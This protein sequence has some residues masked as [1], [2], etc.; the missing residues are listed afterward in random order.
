MLSPARSLQSSSIKSSRLPIITATFLVAVLALAC[1]PPAA[2]GDDIEVWFEE[3]DH[4]LLDTNDDREQDTISFSYDVDTDARQGTEVHVKLLVKNGH[5][6]AIDDPVKEHEVANDTVEYWYMNWTA[7][8]NDTYTF[9]LRLYHGQHYKEDQT[10]T[11]TVDLTGTEQTGRLEVYSI[12]E[13][14]GQVGDLY[15]DDEFYDD[16]EV[17]HGERLLD[18]LE[19]EP[20]EYQVKLILAND[21]SVTRE[22]EVETGKTGEVELLLEDDEQKTAVHI[23]VHNRF[24]GQMSDLYIDSQLV[25]R[26]QLSKGNNDLGEFE[27]DPG[28]H[29]AYIELDNEAE[30]LVEFTL[31]S[32][33]TEN[34]TLNPEKEEDRGLLELWVNNEFDKQWGHLYIDHELIDEFEVEN[35]QKHL[36]DLHLEPGEH[37]VY[38]VLDNEAD[39]GK[40]FTIQKDKRTERVL[41]PTIKDR[42]INIAGSVIS[43]QNCTGPYDD[44]Y[45]LA[46]I[47]DEPIQGV[48]I[49]VYADDGRG[50]QPLRSGTTN[51]HGWWKT[52]ELEPGRYEWEAELRDVILEEG[53]L[54]VY[55]DLNK[56][57]QGDIYGVGEGENRHWDLFKV[58]ADGEGELNRAK[59]RLTQEGEP[60]AQGYTDREGVFMKDDLPRGWYDYEIEWLTDR[61]ETLALSA[62]QIYSYGAGDEPEEPRLYEPDL[63]PKHGD[64][65]TIFTVRVHYQ[66][67]E[68][69]APL[70]VKF[71]YTDDDY[72]QLQATGS[73]WT[74]GVEFILNFSG[75]RLGAGEY[76]HRFIAKVGDLILK[77][78]EKPGPFIN[79]LHPTI[80]IRAPEDG[81][82][83]IGEETAVLMRSD[84]RGDGPFEIRL[85][86]YPKDDGRGGDGVTIF[87]RTQQEPGEK[88][89]T[90]T[91]NTSKLEPGA[92]KLKATIKGE[93]GHMGE[94]AIGVTKPETTD[95]KRDMALAIEPMV[96]KVKAGREAMFTITV[97]NTGNVADS[98]RLTALVLYVNSSVE[99][100]EFTWKDTALD[101]EAGAYG[102]SRLIVHVPGNAST[103]DV[104]ALSVTVVSVK[105]PGVSTIGYASVLVISDESGGV[106]PNLSTPTAIAALTTGVVVASFRRR[107]SE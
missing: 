97:T 31:E 83:L 44:L 86:Y 19:L 81:D 96:R 33:E 57:A 77:T 20:G 6:Q 84:A 55:E 99:G 107:L 40:P 48:E 25:D 94:D 15:L 37:V 70:W 61:N 106:M 2:G 3:V 9:E 17:P 53:A 66:D 73:R 79:D 13:F 1:M 32:G 72:L 105:D 24:D 22:A 78:D 104:M 58:I 75:E 93:H 29:E 36:V 51:S 88:D 63:D 102:Q 103:G 74:E 26:Y 49:A 42:T 11:V 30:H 18:T 91:W 69:R 4:V 92:Y 21:A 12:N 41:T 101:I 59:V 60:I 85:T 23:H 39:D 82:R 34:I 62:S 71:F 65:E 76:E 64:L 46:H 35:G 16:Y 54:W 52:H 7:E 50:R 80:K 14:E 90:V 8:T 28:S 67:P 98:Y 43:C 95:E 56:T 45:F 89:W 10:R 27:L 47:R 68:G 87:E 5:G 38:L 100:W